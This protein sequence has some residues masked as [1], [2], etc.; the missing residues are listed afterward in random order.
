MLPKKNSSP[1]TA[2]VPVRVQ[3]AGGG[4]PPAPE[5]VQSLPMKLL[6]AGLLLS[7][8]FGGRHLHQRRNG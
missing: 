2:A 5:L 8:P 7:F 6:I 3:I 1:K 4:F